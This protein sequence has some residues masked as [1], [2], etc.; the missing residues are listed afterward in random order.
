MSVKWRS[1]GV[2]QK[3][4]E[5]MVEEDS[6]NEDTAQCGTSTTQDHNGTQSRR[7]LSSSVITA[8]PSFLFG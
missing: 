5:G 7:M 1:Q 8:L 4:I 6:E 3:R 2:R